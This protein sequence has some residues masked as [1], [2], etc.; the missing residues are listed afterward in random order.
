MNV[1]VAMVDG[2]VVDLAAFKPED[3]SIETVAHSLALQCRF[4]GHTRDFYSVA[5]HCV[6]VSHLI[7]KRF[8]LEGL[9]HDAVEAYTGDIPTPV[10]SYA[11]ELNGLEKRLQRVIRKKFGLS[12]TEDAQRHVKT[13]DVRALKAEVRDL[14]HPAAH[15]Y[16]HF[17]LWMATP[18]EVIRAVSP[19]EAETMFLKRY[20]ELTRDA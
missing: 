10:K 1:N 3:V 18:S 16:F 5:Q 11:P 7:D 20:R 2:R 4:I 8:A 15:V 13:C 12:N 14:I 9:L 17:P 19:A 6:I